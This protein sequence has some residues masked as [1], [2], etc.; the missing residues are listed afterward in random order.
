M[1]LNPSPLTPPPPPDSDH[2]LRCSGHL[3]KQTVCIPLYICTIYTFAKDFGTRIESLFLISV[4]KVFHNVGA[5]TERDL[6]RYDFTKG[7]FWITSLVAEMGC[8]EPEDSV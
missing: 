3:L 7:D 1:G 4:C 6:M 5:A 2:V 8:M